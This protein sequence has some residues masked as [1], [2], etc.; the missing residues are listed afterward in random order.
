MI[1]LNDDIFQILLVPPWENAGADHWMSVWQ[2]KYPRW[3]RVEQRNWF[4]PDK[5]EWVETLDRAIA[6]RETEDLILVAHSL[7]T[8]TLAHWANKFDR[9]AVKGALLVAPPDVERDDA[10]PEI[11]TFAPVPLAEFKFPSVVVAS[12]NDNY[13]SVD[14]ARFFAKRWGSRFINIGRAGHI[15]VKSGHGEWQHG[16][17]ILREFVNRLYSRREQLL[18]PK[19]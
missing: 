8:I 16:E 15:N 6:G 12:E 18:N 4:E 1:D 9:S 11:Q 3:Q 10:P 14:R 5:N 17:Q 7:G 2:R 13:I 19:C